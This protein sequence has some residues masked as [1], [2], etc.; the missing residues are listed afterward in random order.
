[1]SIANNE[2]TKALELTKNTFGDNSVGFIGKDPTQTST[3]K[4]LNTVIQLL[5]QVHTRLGV[6]EDELN[7]IK[8]ARPS[9]SGGKDYSAELDN[10]TNRLSELKVGGKTTEEKGKLKVL[11]KF[12]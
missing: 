3:A 5:I 12:W 1:M 7:K 4:Q 6:I 8:T 9:T 11:K 2:Y 10:I